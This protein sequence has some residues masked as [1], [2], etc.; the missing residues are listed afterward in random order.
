MNT[1]FFISIIVLLAWGVRLIRIDLKKL[2]NENSELKKSNEELLQANFKLTQK[3]NK[4]LK[5]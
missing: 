2:E 3:S 5:Y 4:N 1:V